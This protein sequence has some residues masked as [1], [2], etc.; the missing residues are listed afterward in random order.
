V[1]LAVSTDEALFVPRPTAC[2]PAET[3]RFEPGEGCSRPPSGFAFDVFGARAFS[4]AEVP[5][6]CGIDRTG[7]GGVPNMALPD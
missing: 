5:S 7:N 1:D 4:D 6:G 2:A 3:R